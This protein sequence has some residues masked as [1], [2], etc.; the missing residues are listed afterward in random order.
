MNSTDEVEDGSGQLYSSA[1]GSEDGLGGDHPLRIAVASSNGDRVDRHFGQTDDL[2]VFDVNANGRA[3]VEV[4]NIDACAFGEEDR[5][6]TIY[7]LVADCKVLL[8]AKIGVTPQEK[9]ASLGVEGIDKHANAS[10]DAALL[11]V[12][13]FT[14]NRPT[15]KVGIQ[16]GAQSD[17]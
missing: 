14:T 6:Q 1:A 16:T 11:D 17:L 3:L 13:H 5:R 4:R 12:Y 7:R 2:W 15:A 10:V 9:L 8:I